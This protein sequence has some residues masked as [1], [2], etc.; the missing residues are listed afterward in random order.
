MKPG[1]ETPAGG[2]RDLAEAF[3]S[4]EAFRAEVKAFDARASVDFREFKPA[5]FETGRAL[6]DAE[7]DFQIAVILAAMSLWAEDG[8][9][10]DGRIDT[11]MVADLRS[12]LAKRKLPFTDGDVTALAAFIDQLTAAR[13]PLDLPLLAAIDAMPRAGS[14]PRSAP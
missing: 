5:R 2:G 8:F 12:Q 7:P 13:R 3:K 1:G 10:Y 9:G 14:C 6:L 4:L 11:K